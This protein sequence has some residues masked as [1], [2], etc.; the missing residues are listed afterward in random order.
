MRLSTGATIIVFFI[1][2]MIVFI[3]KTLLVSVFHITLIAIAILVIS[4]ILAIATK[5]IGRFTQQ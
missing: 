5:I 4:G 2:V 1:G 3:L